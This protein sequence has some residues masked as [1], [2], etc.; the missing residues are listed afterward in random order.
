MDNNKIRIIAVVLLVFVLLFLYWFSEQFIA[1]GLISAPYDKIAHAAFGGSVA[2][3]L[4]EI[5]KGHFIWMNLGIVT[6]LSGLEEWH[7]SFLPGRV[8]DFY[9]FL[10]ATG[11]ACLCLILLR[12]RKQ[13]LFN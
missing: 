12:F 11:A 5:L 10:A 4:W 2:F 7:Q 3:F 8:P 9:D 6:L 1:V 13:K